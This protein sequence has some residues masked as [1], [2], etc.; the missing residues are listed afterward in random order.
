MAKDDLNQPLRGRGPERARR[1]RLVVAPILISAALLLGILAAIWVAV[2]DDPN[3]GRPQAVA[4]IEEITLPAATGSLEDDEV[5]PPAPGPG[6][7]TVPPEDTALELPAAEPEI[8]VAGLPV[9]PPPTAADASLVEPS[10][11]GLLPRVSP[12]GRRAREIYARR[13]APVPPDVPRVVLVVAGLGLSQTGTQSAIEELPEDVTLAFAAFGASLPRWVAKAREEG[14]EIILQMPLE[15]NGYPQTNPG[16]HT[17]LT[18]GFDP[19][20]FHWMLGRMTAYAGVMNYMGGRFTSDE[21]SLVPFLGEIGER[22]LYYLDDGSSPE[23][24][25]AIVG[26]ALRV[27]VLTADRIIDRDRN[28]ASIEKELREL[29]AIARTRGLAVGVASA[30]PVSVETVARWMR[31]AAGRGIVVVPVSAALQST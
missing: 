2:V 13:S 19:D 18:G 8:Q 20:D 3:G 21:K 5:E 30:F 25:T 28:S 31:E 16:P 24:R 23:S 15:P 14:H 4:T 12:D 11:F 1:R 6:A 27:P 22:G 29:E 10:A 26:E 7:M 17:L 9:V